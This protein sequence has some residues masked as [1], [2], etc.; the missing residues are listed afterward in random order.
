[1]VK[2]LVVLNTITVSIGDGSSVPSLF[3]VTTLKEGYVLW[4]VMLDEGHVLWT[5]N[6]GN[7]ELESFHFFDLILDLQVLKVAH[8]VGHLSFDIFLT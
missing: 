1:V 8:V 2:F 3:A 7:I 5:I 6:V 4:T